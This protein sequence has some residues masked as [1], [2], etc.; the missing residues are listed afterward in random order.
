MS[1]DTLINLITN[2]DQIKNKKKIL[3]EHIRLALYQK[4][5]FLKAEIYQI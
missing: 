3:L 5:E 2:R 4:I 1:T